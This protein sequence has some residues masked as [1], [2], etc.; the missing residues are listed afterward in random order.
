M[1]DLNYM[2]I[3]IKLA[4]LIVLVVLILMNRKKVEVTAATFFSI[5]GLTLANAAIAVLW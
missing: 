5:L 4:V 2:K 1:P 3:G